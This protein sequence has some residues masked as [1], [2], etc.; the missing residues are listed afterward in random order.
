MVLIINYIINNYVL[1][2]M[3][4]GM[5]I[6]TV[7]DVFLYKQKLTQ[8]RITLVML[9][10]LSV[11]D[12]L[13]TYVSK[14]G[15]ID[16]AV[17]LRIFFAALCYSLRPAI[18][19]MLVFITNPKSS[20]LIIIPAV[21]NTVTSFSGFFTKIVFTI[22]PN[23]TFHRGPLGYLPYIISLLYIIGLFITAFRVLAKRSFEES[24]MVM[25]LAVAGSIAA[26]LA[27]EQHSEVVNPT[28]GA[29][30]LLYYLYVYSQYTKCDA[31][32]GLYNRQSFYSDIEKHKSMITGIVSM[33]MNELKW[34]NDTLGHEAGDKALKTVADCF[35][36][37]AAPRDKIYRVGGDEFFAVCRGRSAEEMTALVDKM[38]EAVNGSGY[39]C[40]F[41]LSV[42]GSVNEMI[43]EADAL[44]YEDKARLK[45]AAAAQGRE[46][47]MRD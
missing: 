47:H 1:L 19:M 12:D 17:N 37:S 30:I 13:E 21:V 18:V 44:M 23:N 20:K 42:G 43:K 38:R 39:S 33:D 29:A 41:G 9:F 14:L 3:I 25:F 31:L 22:N 26:F 35:T 6:L 16:F 5:A 40:A 11:F 24:V 8:L 45:S 32:T 46:L 27:S 7:F 4:V 36:R 15:S 10:A 2:I 34:M 28:Y